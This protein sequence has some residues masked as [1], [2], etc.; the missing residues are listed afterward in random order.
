MRKIKLISCVIFLV[1][2]IFFSCK[3]ETKIIY[4][5]AALDSSYLSITNAS[6]SISNLLFYVDNN[7]IPLPDSPFSFGTTTFHTYINSGNEINPTIQ[8]LPY[9]KIPAGYRQLSFNSVSPNGAFSM[10][11]YFKLGVNYSIF[12]TD[13]V[14][15]GQAQCVLIQ[16]NIGVTDSTH[17]LIRF[18][19]LSPDSPPLDLYAFPYAGATGYKVF[20]NC[21]YLPNDYNSV[22]N[23]QSFS[24]I[25]ALPYYF[26]ATETGT[27]NVILE[28]GLVINGKSVV[29]IYA[30]GF[31]AGT[32]ASAVDVGVISYQQK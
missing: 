5:T 30:K 16:D 11:S 22:V 32:G 29:T 27:N 3:K 6:P 31:V 28:G 10:N 7:F 26:V 23:A 13:T 25:D 15:H 19:N 20:S 2:F 1:G 17:G 21:G 14:A 24:P 18:L 4:Q 9:I 8:N 12:I